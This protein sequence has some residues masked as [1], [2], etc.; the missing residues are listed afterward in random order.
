MPGPIQIKRADVAEAIRCLAALKGVSITDAIS[1]AVNAQLAIEKVKA[2]AKLS[3]RHAAA[4]RIL[5]QLRSLPVA[6]PALTD[7]D[8]YDENGLPK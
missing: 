7:A 8:L 2:S 6:G 1:D 3:K 4:N 5:A